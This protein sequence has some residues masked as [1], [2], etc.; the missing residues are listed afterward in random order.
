MNNNNFSLIISSC[1]KYSD[2]WDS[3]LYFLNKFWLNRDFNTYLVTDYKPNKSI[4]GVHFLWD[5][6][7]HEFSDRLL[8]SLKSIESNF[9]LLT[10][11]DY[12]LKEKVNFKNILNLI[13][14]MIIYSAD[15]CR[16][17]DIPKLRQPLII[18]DQIQAINLKEEK[19]GYLINFY[20]GLWR[21]KTLLKI[22]KSFQNYSPW[23]LEA[24]LTN[25]AIKNNLFCLKSNE[26]PFK[27][28]DIVRKGYLLNSS[29]KF[30][31]IHNIKISR[32]SLPYSKEFYL[33]FLQKLKD[34]LP[35]PIQKLIKNILIFFGYKFYS[36]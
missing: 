33:Y 3:H 14:F 23:K 13:D 26:I 9:I 7:Y 36:K 24:E 25:Y 15:Y 27:I 10:F 34:F 29:K 30:L 2:L 8:N 19:S 31:E 5:E 20:P 21:T 17:Y 16:L 32:N 18:N 28:E 4:K 22:L 35:Y 6:N 12:F 1:Q 11:D